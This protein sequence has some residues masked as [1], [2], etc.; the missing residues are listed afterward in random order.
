MKEFWFK[1]VLGLICILTTTIGPAFYLAHT[2]GWKMILAPALIGVAV[3][4]IRRGVWL[5]IE[6][7]SKANGDKRSDQLR[8]C[9]E[10]ECKIE[11]KAEGRTVKVL[12]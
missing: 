4:A 11:P 3:A 2:L 1:S 6:E 12:F 10:I 7:K 5:K 9:Y 8:K